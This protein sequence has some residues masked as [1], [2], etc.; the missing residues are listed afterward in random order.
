MHQTAV[1]CR[2]LLR[3]IAVFDQLFDI[4]R[5][6]GAKIA[7]AVRQL[8]GRHHGVPDVEQ[9]H[10]LHVVDVVNAER[11]ELQL[12]DVEKLSVKPLDKRDDVQIAVSHSCSSDRVKPSDAAT[13]GA[14]PTAGCYSN[15]SDRSKLRLLWF[16]GR[17][18]PLV[19]GSLAW[20]LSRIAR[21]FRLALVDGGARTRV[22]P[23]AEGQATAMPSMSSDIVTVY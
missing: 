3:Q 19:S 9:H 6:V 18:L 17:E 10:T 22:N 7:A 21:H 14:G 11:V 13:A 2:T 23:T 8:G 1:I 20:R 12:R 15:F 5:D 4:V 16:S